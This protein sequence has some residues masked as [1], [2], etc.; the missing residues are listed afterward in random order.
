[1]TQQPET[2]IHPAIAEVLRWFDDSHLSASPQ[3]Q[4]F[5][6]LFKNLAQELAGKLN[7]VPLRE[8]LV[9]LWHAKNLAVLAKAKETA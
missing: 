8:C 5:T 9:S 6:G 4:E 1:M 7:G 2:E 3:L